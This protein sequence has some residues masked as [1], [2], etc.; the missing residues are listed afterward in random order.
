MPLKR[1][2]SADFS[3]E[4]IE[5]G[6]STQS[7]LFCHP[8]LSFSLSF[9]HPSF[10]P[11][12]LPSVSFVLSLPH[13]LLSFLS[14]S[15][16]FFSLYSLF[17]TLLIYFF[18]NLNLTFFFVFFSNFFLFFSFFFRVS[19]NSSLIRFCFFLRFIF[20]FC[21]FHFVFFSIQSCVYS[22]FSN[23]RSKFISILFNDSFFSN[24]F[25]LQY[26]TIQTRILL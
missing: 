12:L 4:V 20:C 10:F 2:A 6:L 26:N 9:F 16:I 18:F 5:N 7:S 15:S 11:S 24:S 3:F 14:S 21:F 13:P 1:P 25:V 19:F 8:Y 17:H 23:I 22:D